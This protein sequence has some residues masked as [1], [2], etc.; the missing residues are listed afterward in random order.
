MALCLIVDSS[1]S[2]ASASASLSARE[3]QAAAGNPSFHYPN[4]P[5]QTLRPRSHSKSR[6]R[7]LEGLGM[8]C[9][10]SAS[11]VRYFAFVQVPV[12]VH[13]TPERAEWQIHSPTL[14]LK[15][16]GM[17]APAFIRYSIIHFE[18]YLT[19]HIYDLL[20]ERYDIS[21]ISITSSG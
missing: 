11:L 5:Q 1:T 14:H 18:G 3:R 19:S 12:E 4:I 7:V 6:H 16:L 10:K 13:F 2:L 15:S 8:M 21:R 20:G 17:Q 9:R